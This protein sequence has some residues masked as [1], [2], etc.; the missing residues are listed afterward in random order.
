[1]T[2]QTVLIAAFSGRALAQSARRAGYRPLV[3][4]AFGDADTRA[5][6][7]EFRVVDGAAR[8]GFRTKPLVTALE[9]LA[10]GAATPPIGLVLGSGFEDKTRLVAALASRHRLLGC[11][12]ETIRACKQPDVL[13]PLL[14]RLGIPHPPTQLTAP[15]SSSDANWLSK[16]IGGSGG[17][18]IRR[19]EGTN[20]IRPRRYFQKELDGT[21]LS[22]GGVF[23]AGGARIAATSQWTA[24]SSREP[25]RYGGA[26]SL[27][28]IDAELFGQMTAAATAVANALA[29]TGMASFDFI[30]LDGIAHLVDVNPRPG[31]ALDVLDD[32]DGY[33]F[34]AHV[35]ACNGAYVPPMRRRLNEARAAAVMHADRGNVTAGAINWPDWSADRPAPGT[36]IHEGDPIA[37][38]FATADTSDNAEQLVRTRLA[39]LETLVYGAQ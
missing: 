8:I 36:D 35:L 34:N 23:S 1:M 19:C 3:A 12:A 5:A 21:R 20:A 28:P 18:H 4:D 31:A 27:P 9:S 32:D 11:D 6:S 14:D 26:A 17:R 10:A 13:M 15:D 25:F 38:A 7:D 2:G 30:V 24:P 33:A 29:L 37:T 22:I 39:E 16:R